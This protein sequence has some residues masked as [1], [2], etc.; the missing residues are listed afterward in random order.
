MMAGRTDRPL[1]VVKAGETPA[2]KAA[3][4]KRAPAKPRTLAQAAK[5]SR[6]TLLETLRDKIANAMDDPRAHPRDVGNLVKQLLDV[7]NQIDALAGKPAGGKK[8]E[9]SAVADTPNEV[10]DEDAI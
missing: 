2:K 3:P 4:R 8:A 9:P 1:S 6:K 7:Q 10:W 5:L